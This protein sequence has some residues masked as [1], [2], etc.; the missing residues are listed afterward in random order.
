MAFFTLTVIF[1][2]P[3]FLQLWKSWHWK[4]DRSWWSDYSSYF[5]YAFLFVLFLFA[6]A[7]IYAD[8]LKE[9]GVIPGNEFVETSG[10]ALATDGVSGLKTMLT[11]LQTGGVLFIDEAYQLNPKLNPSGAAV[12]TQLRLRLKFL[13]CALISA[14]CSQ[15]LNYL[16]PEM[17]NK[18]GSLVVIFAG[19]EKQMSELLEFN[20]GLPSRFPLLFNFLDYSD[21]GTLPQRFI[22]PEF[23]F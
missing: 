4:N 16:L 18:R 3:D 11:K 2:Q 20:E 23:F 10:S 1:I 13:T 8:L 6:V 21:D 15:V 19:Y 14:L 22:W 5:A 12:R 17:E 9:L 7:R